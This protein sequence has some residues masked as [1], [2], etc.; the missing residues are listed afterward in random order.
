[1]LYAYVK[2]HSGLEHG[3]IITKDN[4]SFIVIKSIEVNEKRI[5]KAYDYYCLSCGKQV[6]FRH[7]KAKHDHFYH[8]NS[9]DC[10]LPESIEHL[11][12]KMEI[13]EYLK[14]AGY[15]AKLEKTFFQGHLKARADVFAKGGKE[16]L[17]VE[18]QA[19][20]SITINTIRKRNS[21]YAAAGIPTAWVIVLD[22]FFNKYTGT[23]TTQI[24][25]HEDGTTSSIRMDLPYDKQEV[26]QVIGETPKAFDFLI[27][28]YHYVITI[29][30]EGKF[31]LIRKD[32]N[33]TVYNITRIPTSD[34]VQSLLSTPLIDMDYG[35][36]TNS[37][38]EKPLIFL[39]D[40]GT[41]DH[42]SPAL[43]E[44][45]FIDFENGR[46][47]E[48]ER[49]K[50]E[51][52]FDTVALIQALNKAREE[53]VRETLNQLHYKPKFD[54]WK[55]QNDMIHD[56][57]KLNFSK[58][59]EDLEKK[60]IT[61]W[62]AIEERVYKE[63]F[64]PGL[65]IFKQKLKK[66][67]SGSSRQLKKL[68]ELYLSM[69]KQK[70]NQLAV[71]KNRSIALENERIKQ[72]L[73]IRARIIYEEEVGSGLSNIPL[74][75]ELN[76]RYKEKTMREREE[77]AT[78]KAEDARK[79]EQER[80]IQERMSTILEMEKEAGKDFTYT[81]TQVRNLNGKIEQQSDETFQAS[82]GMLL[83]SYNTI[84]NKKRKRTHTSAQ[85]VKRQDEIDRLI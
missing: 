68:E 31:F 42:P 32:I 17:V 35:A 39:G 10:K 11:L 64:K 24:V 3:S 19:S 18:V 15:D 79:R 48:Q 22:T 59:K 21:I 20:N 40:E 12:V 43:P 52:P 41:R 38:A 49:L 2:D 77:L 26:F 61:Q 83:A 80:I 65:T 36:S 16:E 55:Q 14:K 75:E 47:D 44:S 56:Q 23:T 30:N 82:I 8:R 46:L 60:R 63:K 28:K 67:L 84:M 58:I 37:K 6:F 57:R 85:P 78:R 53:Q 72:E 66:E 25:K 34:L 76:Q 70:A 71:L 1:L 50:T 51:E 62:N 33:G 54:N 5:E 27:D 45:I 9:P 29:S 74:Y 13:Y 81:L 69:Y 73:H 4:Q 7:Y